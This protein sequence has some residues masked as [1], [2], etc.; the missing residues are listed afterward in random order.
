[1][2]HMTERFDFDRLHAR[3]AVIADRVHDMAYDDALVVILD[4]LLDVR[5]Q[6]QEDAI[7]MVE[8]EREKVI[9]ITARIERLERALL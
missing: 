5:R 8:T 6:A 3:A 9:A 7:V 2:A 1:M 4:A